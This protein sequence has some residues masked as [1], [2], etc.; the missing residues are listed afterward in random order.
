MIPVS[1]SAQAAPEKYE[2]KTQAVCKELTDADSFVLYSLD[3]RPYKKREDDKNV[4]LFH[5][6]R[7]LGSLSL[8][9]DEDINRLRKGLSESFSD[10]TTIRGLCFRPRH[11]LRVKKN[12]KVVTEILLCYECKLAEFYD[13]KFRGVI[14]LRKGYENELNTLLMNKNITIAD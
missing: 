1:L 3:P 12:G 14:S 2:L 9:R 8:D 4:Q 7:V 5:D 10:D 6:Y 13:D 11:G